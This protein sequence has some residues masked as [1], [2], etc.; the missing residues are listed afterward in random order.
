LN[1]GTYTVKVETPGF[2]AVI[3]SGVVLASQQT[4]RTDVTMKV[5]S[6]NSTVTVTAGRLGHRDG[7]AF[8]FEY[9]IGSDSD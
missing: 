8:N 5:G 4:L 7:D 3:D 2:A 1:P 6:T 9:R